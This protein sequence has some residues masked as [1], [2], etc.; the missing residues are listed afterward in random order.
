MHIDLP[1]YDTLQTLGFALLS[2][3]II[4]NAAKEALKLLQGQAA[5][6]VGLI[7]KSLL[8]VCVLTAIPTI[9]RTI[10]DISTGI[11]NVIL[12]EA[13]TPLVDRSFAAAFSSFDCPTGL[14]ITRT[15]F[16]GAANF[17]LLVSMLAKLIVL[18]IGW[19]IALHF[20]L[21][22]GV[23]SI[24]ASVFGGG[25]VGGYFKGL[26]SVSTWPVIFAIIMAIIGGMF[27]NDFKNV[28]DGKT[29]IDCGQITKLREEMKDN[30]SAAPV[31]PR[32]DVGRKR[33]GYSVEKSGI[34]KV[35]RFVGVL[36]VLIVMLLSI[37]YLGMVAAGETSPGTM[38]GAMIGGGS[39]GRKGAS[40]AGAAASVATGGIKKGA[41]VVKSGISKFRGR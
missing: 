31:E 30:Q 32:E 37:P 20:V 16:A 23:L 10:V 35:M 2:L 13:Q 38:M 8:S 33:F 12:A 1:I 34:W 39:K 9:G 21:Y 17:V 40:A 14:S 11:C 27:P 25:G 15:L 36:G 4:I 24:P 29:K 7:V 18:D 22:L 6:W 28:I 3:A 41:N 19:T 26:W 5:D